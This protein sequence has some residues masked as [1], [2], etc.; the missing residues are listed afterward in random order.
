MLVEQG[1]SFPEPYWRPPDSK[2][3]PTYCHQREAYLKRQPHKIDPILSV[4]YAFF[5]ADANGLWFASYCQSWAGAKETI[6]VYFSYLSLI[7]KQINLILNSLQGYSS[8]PTFKQLVLQHDEV[9]VDEN[10]YK[11]YDWPAYVQQLHERKTFDWTRSIQIKNTCQRSIWKDLL[12]EYSQKACFFVLNCL[13]LVLVSAP[14]GILILLDIQWNASWPT[15][16]CR[17]PLVFNII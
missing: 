7:S 9:K 17:N 2:N 16:S 12:I 5:V 10:D 8:D 11:P 13:M 1:L 4:I 14:L 3:S 6:D 15:S